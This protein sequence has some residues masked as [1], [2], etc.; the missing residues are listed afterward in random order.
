MKII[1]HQVNGSWVRFPGTPQLDTFK[2]ARL[3]DDGVWSD[4]DLA[5]YGLRAADPFVVPQGKV[6]V[7]EE[8]FSEDGRQQHFDVE[9]APEP[10]PEVPYSISPLQARKALRAAGLKELVDGFVTTLPE[11]QQEEWEYATEIRRDH[12]VIVAGT[13]SLGLTEE[14]VDGLFLLGA[15]L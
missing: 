12:P 9:D 7:G 6:P 3:M 10:E 4:Y 15:A 14:Q 13:A 2:I 5:L 11:E 1:T 8:S